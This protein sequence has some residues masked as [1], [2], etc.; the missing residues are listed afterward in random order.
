MSYQ[1]MIIFCQLE[2]RKL[3]VSSVPIGILLY[4]K[5]KSNF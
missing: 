1:C 2:F 3:K 5:N 4:F